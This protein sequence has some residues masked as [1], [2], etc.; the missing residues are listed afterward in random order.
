MKKVVILFLAALFVAA[1]VPQSLSAGVGVKAGYSLS[2]FSLVSTEPPPFTF[3]NLPSV[4][5]GIYLEIKLGFI[6]LQPEIL[7][8]RMGAKYESDPVVVE[9]RFDYVQAPVLLKINVIPAGPVRPFIYGGGYGSYL[10]KARGF[11][12]DGTT[13]E[14]VDLADTFVKYDYGVVGGAGLAFKLPGISI[15]VEGRYNYGLMNTLKDPAAGES[16]KNRSMMALVGI[17]F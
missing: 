8:T 17:G 4:V 13:P 7:Y 5:G 3:G 14:T 16:V 12:T 2:K 9:Y 15:S 10:L 6:S 1:L 11:M